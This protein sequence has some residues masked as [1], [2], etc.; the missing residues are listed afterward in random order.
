MHNS[1]QSPIIQLG[2]RFLSPFI[3]LFGMY[4]IALGHYGPGGGFQGGTF[5]AASFIL[6]RL[7]CGSQIS[8]IHFPEKFTPPYSVL[9]IGIYFGTGLVC[10]LMGGHFLDYSHLPLPTSPEMRRYWGLF[11]IEV[12]V[13]IAVMAILILIYDNLLKGEDA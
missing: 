3:M 7:A 13:G 11:F 4:L 2:A 9:G 5:L 6:V 12:G 8:S 1:L 10:A